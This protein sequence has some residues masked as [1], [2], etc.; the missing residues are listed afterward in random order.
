MCPHNCRCA[1]C[2]VCRPSVSV[3]AKV[4]TRF[5]LGSTAG[6]VV[7]GMGRASPELELS[8]VPISGPETGPRNRSTMWLGGRVSLLT[9]VPW[10]GRLLRSRFRAAFWIQK[11]EAL[12]WGFTLL[13]PKCRPESG[14][15]KWT[16]QR[17]NFGLR[18]TRKS[19]TRP[20]SVSLKSAA[21]VLAKF[22][23]R[24]RASARWPYG[25][26]GRHVPVTRCQA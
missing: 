2:S 1:V 6:G 12:L 16:T 20:S 7:R 25:V 15:Q 23:P 10:C 3:S 19:H 11:G 8:E 24:R 22:A 5:R 17:G 26:P 9:S 21:V 4:E 18:S 14:P 13:N